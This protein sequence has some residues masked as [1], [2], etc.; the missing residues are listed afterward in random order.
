VRRAREL[1]QQGLSHEVAACDGCPWRTAQINK[2]I[3]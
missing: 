3:P 2:L 1:H